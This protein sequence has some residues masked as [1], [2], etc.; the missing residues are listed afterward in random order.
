M[1]NAG[2]FIYTGSIGILLLMK[3]EI[4]VNALFVCMLMVI[5][6]TTSSYGH[7]ATSG[8]Q[9]GIVEKTGQT[10]PMD[11]TF[12]DEDG[13]AVKLKDLVNKPT[14]LTLVY[15]SCSGICPQMLGAL[16]SALGGVR[17]EPGKDYEVM[18][19]S[20][21]KDDT[22][23]ASKEKRLNYIY[24]TGAAFPADAWRFLTG[25]GE[26]IDLLTKAVGFSFQKE[27][28]TGT[29][30]F[31]SPRESRGFIHPAVLIF[32][33]PDGKIIKYMYLEQSHYGTAESLSF[34]SSEITA[35]L[36]DATKGKVRAGPNNPIRLCFP[37]I[38]A[39]QEQFY[40]IMAI[41]GAVALLSVVAL[42][43]YLRKTGKKT[44]RG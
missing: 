4:S 18:T 7:E 11:I 10:V 42:F 12:L 29:V 17:L 1:N 37:G 28:S 30:G 39:Q 21:D 13:A 38:S 24:A 5:I 15:Y 8:N 44:D 25:K 34:S 23:A 14:I 22:P 36:T 9:A 20:F 6:P 40:T 31:G 41:I 2:L 19:I 3:S 26:S 32:L 33:A 16:A 35:A 27:S 43:V